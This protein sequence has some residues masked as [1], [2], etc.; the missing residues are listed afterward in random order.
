MP[1]VLYGRDYWEKLINFDEM[2]KWGMISPEDL[3]LFKMADTIDAAF[4]YLKSELT[5][6]YINR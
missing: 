1:I 6:H 3:N 2:I 5:K 4:S